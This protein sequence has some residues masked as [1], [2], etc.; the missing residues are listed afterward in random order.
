MATKTRQLADYLVAGGVSDTHIQSVP[1]IKP[2]ILQPA[3]AGKL[4]DG[5]TNHSG[6][7]G[8]AQ[9]DGHSY[10]YTDIKGS[11]PIKDPRIGAYFGSQ[12]HMFKSMQLLKQE[13]A[14][15]G[16]NVYSID[17]REWI[18]GVG[19]LSYVNSTGSVYVRLADVTTSFF[20]ITGYFNAFNFIAL[21]NDTNRSLK[22]EV[23][24]V[25]ATT[26]FNP[27]GVNNSPLALRYV[28][29]GSV[30]NVDI[31]SSSSLSS[32]TTLGIHT[33]RISYASGYGNYP[34]GCE[35]IAQ[36][37]SS[38]A[39]R[40]KIQ[41]PSQ[42]V[43]SYGKK[44]S[45]SG[46]PHYDPF[47]GM[48]GAKT[49]AQLGD[50]IDT[51]TSLGMENWKGGTSNYYKPFNGGRVVKWVASDGT[52]KTSVTMMP[53][54]AQNY[55]GT[56]SNAVSDAHIQAGTNDD[57]INFDTTTIANATPLSEVAKT[58][59]W[60][61]FGNGSANGGTAA[62]TYAD[63]SM[64]SQT[65]D[66]IAYVMDD[67]LTSLWAN[68]KEGGN[69]LYR[70]DADSFAYSTF[71]GTGITKTVVNSSIFKSYTI[72]QN[73]PYGTHILRQDMDSSTTAADWYIDGVKIADVA[74]GSPNYEGEEFFYDMII[75]QP[76][77]PPIPEDACILADYM[78]MAD[79]LK[80]TNT[81]AKPDDLSKGVRLQ[82]ATRDVFHDRTGG[83]W[84]TVTVKNDTVL[85]A[86]TGMVVSGANFTSATIKLP[87]FGITKGAVHCRQQGDACDMAL[88][89]TDSSGSLESTNVTVLSD[90]TISGSSNVADL[91]GST[92]YGAFNW[93]KSDGVLG[94]N[95]V[96]M[97]DANLSGTYDW[98]YMYA[99]EV[100]TPIHTSSH[101]QTFETPYLKELVGG[102]R[103]MEQTN[104]I[105]T[106]D[107]KSW[108]E[109]TRDTSYI[110][111]GCLHADFD[112]SH[113]NDS[114]WVIW[115]EWR[116]EGSNSGSTGSSARWGLYNKDFAIAYDRVI[117]L[118]D[119]QYS[120]YIQDQN[121]SDTSS[122]MQCYING[123]LYLKAYSGTGHGMVNTGPF[124]VQLFRGDYIQIKGNFNSYA[125]ICTYE[126][127]RI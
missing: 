70:K 41:I 122:H 39:N 27:N 65:E 12:R 60:R 124:N 15:H 16:E 121:S 38:T 26:T 55:G 43:V 61:E 76:K 9:S 125:N 94:T 74:G 67:G 109:V 88:T 80:S 93:Q 96:Q 3:I 90:R 119:G 44:F 58:I 17:G 63:A 21:S 99:F 53:P 45:I 51:A 34:T 69:M 98:Y 32:D 106:S 24:G 28:S 82:S 75:H 57:T 42:N 92:V 97:D 112:G 47:N 100:A 111:K 5:T 103:N 68:C 46:T 37:T 29:S 6:A 18:R 19:T 36:D 114:T 120:I 126:I 52:I 104:L 8:T 110:G 48:S 123:V 84:D 117:C 35:L 22:V 1:H 101:Y 115:D 72:A 116:G 66:D 56:A 33:I 50:Y 81:S 86:I 91:S 62:G 85:N 83:A 54:N 77:K 25:T 108:D 11:K 87:Y 64:L 105:V 4:L 13:T 49:L 127:T 118:V 23:D 14:T 20:E 7:Y 95:I 113:A 107:G 71:I 102:D 31:T 40:S 10:Y 79:F 73:L 78:L 59:Y 30:N 2:G 89:V